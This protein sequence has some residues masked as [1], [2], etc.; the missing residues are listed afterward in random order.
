M[1]PRLSVNSAIRVLPQKPHSTSNA[2]HG[3]NAIIQ[4]P[5]N[6][7]LVV[8]LEQQLPQS[9]HD[10]YEHRSCSKPVHSLH[11]SAEA[12]HYKRGDVERGHSRSSPIDTHTP[13]YLL[14]GNAADMMSATRLKAEAKGQLLNG[15]LTGRRS[16]AIGG[17]T[18]GSP[19]LGFKFWAFILRAYT[20]APVPVSN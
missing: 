20:T 10:Q 7:D 8:S 12:N 18:V 9:E 13:A 3:T 4:C 5:R 6:D 2:I 17:Q 15:S 14:A 16:G 1:S 11:N 19:N